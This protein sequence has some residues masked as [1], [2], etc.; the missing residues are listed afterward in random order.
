MMQIYTKGGY[1]PFTIS[2]MPD[3]QPHFKLD[4]DLRE[5]EWLDAVIEVDM[6]HVDILILLLA[7]DTLHASGYEVSLDI[8]YMLGA[9]MDRR[10]SVQEPATLSV[11]CRL[12]RGA[13]FKRIRVLDPHS[14]ATLNE[15][16][17]T[18]VWPTQQV[19]MALSGRDSNTTVL[20]APD[21]GAAGRMP[22]YLTRDL[23][24]YRV[25]ECTK[26]RDPH[27]GSLSDPKIIDA[28]AVWGKHCLIV[29][30]ICDGGRTFTQLAVQLRQAG[31]SDIDLFVTHGIFSKGTE[32]PGIDRVFTTDS[33]RRV[34][35]AQ[36]ENLT[37]FPILMRNMH[38]ESPK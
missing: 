20:V 36:Y 26:R 15:L 3:G 13:G 28:S 34:V 33:T 6:R 38:P 17:A 22:N 1:I 10:I 23:A 5:R 2:R 21:A 4:V 24:S 9:R 30:D 29:D 16:G 7:A 31:A 14:Q 35:W 18:G 25:V 19:V 37:V 27:D 8:R 32:I 12:I 11:I